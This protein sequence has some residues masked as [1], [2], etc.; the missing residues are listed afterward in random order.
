VL[1]SLLDWPGAVVLKDI[2]EDAL[3]GLGS[4]VDINAAEAYICRLRKKIGQS[5]IEAVAGLG[6][7]LV[8]S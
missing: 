1:H 5:R 7:R 4:E 2:I 8:L 3:Y 6:Y